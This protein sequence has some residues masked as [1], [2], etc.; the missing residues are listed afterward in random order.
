MT[1]TRYRR[2]STLSTDVPMI[3]LQVPAADLLLREFRS[4]PRNTS[5][6]AS[7]CLLTGARHEHEHFR[8]TE[9]LDSFFARLDAAPAT[10]RAAILAETDPELRAWNESHVAHQEAA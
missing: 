4:F 1:I 2:G 8:I 5:W 7:Y 9:I 3:D 10:V 6:Y